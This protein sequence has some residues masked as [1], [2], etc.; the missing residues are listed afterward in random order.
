M[1]TLDTS[2]HQSPEMQRDTQIDWIHL[3]IIYTQIQCQNTDRY[4]VDRPASILFVRALFGAVQSAMIASWGWFDFLSKLTVKIAT[5][6]SNC[7]GGVEA[8][9]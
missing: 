4:E 9:G 6:A 2:E 8:E 1:H 5:F 3:S 7:G